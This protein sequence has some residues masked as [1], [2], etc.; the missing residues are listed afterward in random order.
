MTVEEL[1]RALKLTHNAVRNQLRKLESARLIEQSGRRPG[2]SKPSAL[3]S[4]TLGGQMLFST[5]Y[6]PV[7][8]EF[9]RVAEGQC[10]GKQLTSFMVNTGKSLARNYQKPSG[11]TRER[12][13]E[14]AL[15]LRRFGGLTEIEKQNG[16]L[17]LRSKACPLAALTAENNTACR[18]IEGLLKEYL[19]TPVRTC[20][21]TKP[22]PQCCFVIGAGTARSIPRRK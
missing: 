1:A 2:V 9:L 4:I 19:S 6:L 16:S 5:L 17:V 15:L 22:E 21:E 7:L 20:C 18:V 14:A 13:N 10:E 8:S 11:N 12:V 3:Y